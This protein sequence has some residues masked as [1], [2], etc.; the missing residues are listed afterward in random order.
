MST[1]DTFKNGDVDYSCALT[2]GQMGFWKWDKTFPG[3]P[4]LNVC[5][6]WRYGSAFDPEIARQTIAAIVARHDALRTVFAE[7][8]GSVTQHILAATTSPD[9]TQKSVPDLA[10]ANGEAL[11]RDLM[12]TRLTLTDRPPFRYFLLH[13]AS[14]NWVVLSVFHHI[15]ADGWSLG[16]FA[17]EFA[18]TY[19]AIGA[20][21]PDPAPPLPVQYGDYVVHQNQQISDGV[22]DA[23]LDFFRQYLKN[24]PEPAYFEPIRPVE[25][26][27]A[28]FA[29]D[30]VERALPD[31]VND[32]LAEQV[33]TSRTAPYPILL[34]CFFVYTYLKTGKTDLAVGTPSSGRHLQEVEDMIGFFV[35]TVPIMHSLDP[36]QRFSQV[37]QE[38]RDT[39]LNVVAHSAVP[40]GR[41]AEVLQ[42]KVR[43]RV[44]PYFNLWF[45]Y[46]AYNLPRPDLPD[47]LAQTVSVDRHQHWTDL[48][49]EVRPRGSETHIECVVPQMFGGREVAEEIIDE[50]LQIVRLLIAD[51]DR[52]IS[53]VT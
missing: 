23:D 52:I 29:T 8:D 45:A 22:L 35:N 18:T 47:L 41:V 50:Y 25:W 48:A 5:G 9:I 19:A 28:T 31:D 33:R 20:G 6:C 38:V 16:N 43:S 40:S 44:S 2:Y 1:T 27:E 26:T 4:V 46:Q 32:R 7:V 53:N 12:N 14:D 36:T 49:I 3:T 10:G 17:R 37:V 42:P 21:Q 30:T 51:P 24:P 11:L 34:A 15:L 13:E 39:V